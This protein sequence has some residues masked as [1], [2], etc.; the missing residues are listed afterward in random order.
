M[1][2]RDCSNMRAL[3]GIGIL[4]QHAAR[5]GDLFDWL[6]CLPSGRHLLLLRRDYNQN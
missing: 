2:C 1:S 5:I 3:D 6:P 4:S